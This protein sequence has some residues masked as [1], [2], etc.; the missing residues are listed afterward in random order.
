MD[1]KRL[2]VCLSLLIA[3]YLPMMAQQMVSACVV[4][5]ETGEPLP[6]VS[7]YAGEGRGTLT[8]GD[9]DFQLKAMAG[10][11]LVL[12]FVGYEKMR[13]L[14][15]KLPKK[16]RLKPFVF[17][18][19]T[20][21]V[22]PIED[23]DLLERVIKHMERDY[24]NY[25]HLRKLYF[26]RYM[27]QNTQD[28]YLIEGFM[29]AEAV[30]NLRNLMMVTGTHGADM[31]GKKSQIS[32]KSTN[33]HKLMEV[34]SK[35][36][37]SSYWEETIKPLTSIKTLKKHYKTEVKT[38]YGGENNQELL[39]K[40]TF[41]WRKNRSSGVTD[42]R[43]IT[44]TLYVDAKE[45][46]PLRFDG[47][48]NNAF[49]RLDFQRTPTKLSFHMDY[50]YEQNCAVVSNISVEGGNAQMKYRT[51]LFCVDDDTLSTKQVETQYNLLGTI[52]ESGF[53]P[54]LWAKYDIVKRTREEEQV[55]FG[56]E[57]ADSIQK[58]KEKDLTEILVN[59]G[60]FAPYVERMIRFGQNIPQEKVYLHMDN[61]SYFLGDTIW[62]AAYTRQTNTASPSKQSKVLYVELYNNDG[63]LVER[64]MLEMTDGWT[65]GFFALTQPLMYSGFYELRA[66]TRWQLNWGIHE[67]KHSVHS[68]KWFLNKA[69]EKDYYRD[70]DKLYSRVFPIYDKPQDQEHP[71][72]NMTS[73][74]M[75]RYFKKDMDEED[76]ELALTLFPE[77]GYLVAGVENRVAFEAAWNDGEDPM[78]PEGKA[79]MT[80][81]GIQVGDQPIQRGRRGGYAG[82]TRGVFSIV[83]QTG[84]T[85]KVTFST[86]DGQTV[87]AKLPKPEKEGVALSVRQEDTAW[88]IRVNM[89]GGLNPDSLALTIMNEGR[90]EEFHLLGKANA[91]DEGQADS[92]QASEE[93]S[94]KIKAP[95]VHQA[96][97]FDKHGRVWADRLFFVTDKELT[98][99]NVTIK[100]LQDEYEPYER[101]DLEIQ[102]PMKNDYISLSVR[103]GYEE[104]KLF[105]NANIMAEMLLASEVK[106]FIADPGWYFQ[107]DDQAHREA[108]DLLM[109]T[110]GWRRFEW[111]SIAVK[112]AWNLTQPVEKTPIIQGVVFKSEDINSLDDFRLMD[113][114][115]ARENAA[116]ELV[117]KKASQERGADG[118]KK[119]GE[120]KEDTEARTYQTDD[121]VQ[122]D[123]IRQKYNLESKLKHEVRMHAEFTPVTEDSTTYELETETIKGRFQIELPRFY[124]VS[125][126]HLAASDTTKWKP[127][128][129]HHWVAQ[130]FYE[131][132]EPGRYDTAVRNAYPEFYV[133]VSFPYPRFVKP[134]SYYQDHL[135]PEQEAD[136]NYAPIQGDDSTKVLREVPVKARKKKGLKRF[137]QSQPAMIINA[138]EMDNLVYDSGIFFTTEK[139][140]RT[141][142]GDYGLEWPYASLTPPTIGDP[143]LASNDTPSRIYEVCGI[144]PGDKRYK[145]E[146]GRAVPEDSIYSSKY[147]QT[148][149]RGSD[150]RDSE[151]NY[152]N[153]YLDKYVI[154]TDYCPRLEGSK[155]YSGS[156]LPETRIALFPFSDAHR[157]DIYR[158]RHFVLTGFSYTAQCYNPDY[159]RQKATK[160]LKDYRRTLYW[161]PSLK[162]DAN[163]EAQ[164]R[165]YNNSRTTRVKVEAAGQAK[166][167]SL[168]WNR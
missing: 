44:G 34:G 90:I 126:L 20:V 64:K 150:M 17:T 145:N 164:V 37:E 61:T 30:V 84:K 155:R 96:T 7:V 88:K 100:G 141:L 83:P 134:Y 38:M 110:Q 70:Y 2:L 81:Y 62:F 93:I 68:Q 131:T 5:A 157:R 143:G 148:S 116:I 9:G 53:D 52:D 162:L 75:R 160:G 94:A 66:Y 35:T 10:D 50:D 77:G 78:T 31:G 125:E 6:Y 39:Y 95:G 161:N 113:E 43:Y 144:P 119:N 147:I 117:Q 137:D 111:K 11:T 114:I 13:I 98:R 56:N 29:G 8:N 72:R 122:M 128:E 79:P 1:M 67:H 167:G 24:K 124:G 12:S 48:V 91:E 76:R 102:A 152:M 47:E 73:R 46:R 118:Q 54:K 120:S 106:G 82:P 127:G 92:T 16:I 132:I 4:D 154:Y 140:V 22:N 97:V 142:L 123:D 166:D 121:I 130:V 153:D 112:D 19:K 146:S 109:M 108:L 3:F 101:I 149:G 159:S 26:T 136:M 18:M 25:K 105:D 42:K 74:I 86:P 45:Y 14:A 80:E 115:S 104:E 23:M 163:G 49:Q 107:E 135:V 63:Y 168:M 158:D 129:E 40:I 51:L 139:K 58:A 36:F 57:M 87:S 71:E 33:L 27:L 21:T 133:K 156:N 55:A 15:D 89:A 99:P 65:N 69:L 60:E 85:E 151:Y 41:Q 59:A 28:S 32:L 165:C 103:D 138:Y